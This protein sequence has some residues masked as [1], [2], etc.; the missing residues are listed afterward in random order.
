MLIYLQNKLFPL[1]TFEIELAT[2][3]NTAASL[4]LVGGRDSAVSIVTRYAL[5]GFGFKPV[6]G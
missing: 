2:V 3:L 1:T 5:D 4:S 6:W